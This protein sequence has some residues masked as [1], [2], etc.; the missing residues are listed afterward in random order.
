MATIHKFDRSENI[1]EGKA[2]AL[3]IITAAIAVVIGF[4]WA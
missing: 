2:T 3:L 1:S 4:I